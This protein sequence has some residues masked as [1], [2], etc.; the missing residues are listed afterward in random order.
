MPPPGRLGNAA[1]S[2]Q[3]ARLDTI[4]F[5]AQ[6]AIHLS[7]RWILVGGLRYQRFH[8]IAGK[9]RPF[10]LNTDVD[11]RRLMPRAGLVFKLRPDVS[12]LASG[13]QSFRL[14][15]FIASACGARPPEPGESWER[16][17]KLELPGGSSLTASV[18]NINKQNILHI[19]DLAET[20]YNPKAGDLRLRGL[21]LD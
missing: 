3:T 20:S 19:F 9:G 18:F 10:S 5:Y 13:S 15:S 17:V 11:K 14:N 1:N 7:D 21:E 12:L 6:G 2:D 8:Q 4:S 16:G